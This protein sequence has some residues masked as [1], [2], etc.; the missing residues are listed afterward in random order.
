MEGIGSMVAKCVLPQWE[1]ERG[2]R[3]NCPIDD[4]AKHLESP[5]PPGPQMPV[6]TRAC[7][8]CA[9]KR[10]DLARDVCICLVWNC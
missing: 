4:G 6:V 5:T 7:L 2:G 8:C 3:L 1:G 9:K 10:R